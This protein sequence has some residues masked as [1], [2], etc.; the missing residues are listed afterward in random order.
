MRRIKTGNVVVA[1]ERLTRLS[2]LLLFY[3]DKISLF[4]KAVHFGRL[5]DLL[6]LYQTLCTVRWYSSSISAQQ[7]TLSLF[8]SSSP[9]HVY[10]NRFIPDTPDRPSRISEGNASSF[11]PSSYLLAVRGFAWRRRSPPRMFDLSMTSR[12]S[13][14][15]HKNQ[16]A[17]S[18]LKKGPTLIPSCSSVLAS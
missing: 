3:G 10:V 17:F 11:G 2:L 9:S 13:W 15:N 16:S 6:A 14:A 12:S 5:M 8:H 18:I 7:V 1:L 4:T